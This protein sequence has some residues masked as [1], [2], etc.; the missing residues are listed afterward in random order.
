VEFDHSIEDEKNERET[1]KTF[2]IKERSWLDEKLTYAPCTVDGTQIL[3]H[4]DNGCTTLLI[5]EQ[6]CI[7]NDIVIEKTR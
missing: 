3:A 1:R 5:G 6:F 7:D 2:L 4:V